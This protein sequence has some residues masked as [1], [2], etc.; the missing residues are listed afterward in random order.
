MFESC[1]GENPKFQWSSD[2]LRELADELE[3]DGL[4]EL[5]RLARRAVEA[6]DSGETEP[7]EGDG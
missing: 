1:F 6:D 3:R 4:Y 5:A 7:L 2:R